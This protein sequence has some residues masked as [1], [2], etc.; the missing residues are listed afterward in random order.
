[1]QTASLP[2]MVYVQYKEQLGF[3]GH[4]K[5]TT[6]VVIPPQPRNMN[7]TNVH[8]TQSSQTADNLLLD[9]DKNNDYNPDNVRSNEQL[10]AA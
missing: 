7:Q 1:M 3:I 6:K 10:T 2:S 9:A 4:V 8:V 5:V